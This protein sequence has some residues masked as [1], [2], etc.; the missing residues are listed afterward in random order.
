MANYADTTGAA[1][2]ARLTGNRDLV[3]T[4]NIAKWVAQGK[5][6]E[7]GQGLQTAAI[8]SQA[9]TTLAPD[10]VLA[11]WAL[12]A[13][14]ATSPLIIPIMLRVCWEAEGGALTDHQLIF[15]KKRTDCATKLAVTGRVP[16]SVQNMN[17]GKAHIPAASPLYGVATTFLVT[18]SALVDADNVMY[19]FSALVDNNVSVPVVGS[20]Q[21]IEWDFL[22]AGAPHILTQGAAMIFYIS[23]GGADA[24]IHPYMQ[25]AEVEEADLV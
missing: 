18:V 15:T 8:E 9:A 3:T 6:F 4:N 19:D 1:Q 2:A 23:S 16:V 12:V 17:K 5:V 14:Q 7:A 13:P 20:S 24:K 22:T 11:T 25:W 21:Q 10:D